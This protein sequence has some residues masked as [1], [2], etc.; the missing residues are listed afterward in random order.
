MKQFTD[1]EKQILQAK[2][3]DQQERRASKK[4]STAS[5]YGFMGFLFCLFVYNVIFLLYFR[6]VGFILLSIATVM[7]L[8]DCVTSRHMKTGWQSLVMKTARWILIVF[9][10]AY[11]TYRNW[12]A[13]IAVV[14][15]L[16]FNCIESH[17]TK[18]GWPE[19]VIKTV[20]WIRRVFISACIVYVLWLAFVA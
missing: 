17:L 14:L 10:C 19:I 2:I 8:F 15:M 5:K 16:L 12:I 11:L 6:D 20:V 7:L 18:R 13:G 1:A 4:E 9:V 3:K